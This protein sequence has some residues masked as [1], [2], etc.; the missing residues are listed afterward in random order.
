M[1]LRGV[2]LSIRNQAMFDRFR[3]HL[4]HELEV[5]IYG[6]GYGQNAAIECMYC[7]EVLVDFD[8]E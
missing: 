4:G 8:S 5:A 2:T 7:N 3:D 6:T 1:L